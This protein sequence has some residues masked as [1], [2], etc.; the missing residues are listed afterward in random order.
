MLVFVPECC[1][2]VKKTDADFAMDPVIPNLYK[3]AKNL[4]KAHVDHIVPPHSAVRR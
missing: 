1:K 4:S 3:F 2:L